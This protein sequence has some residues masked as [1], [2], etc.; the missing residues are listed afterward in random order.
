[1]PRTYALGAVWVLILAIG[2]CSES[3]TSGPLDGGQRDASPWAND[4][5][6]APPNDDDR[7][8]FANDLD[9]CP[10]VFNADQLDFDKDGVGDPCDPDPPPETCGDAVVASARM[11]PNVLVVLD[12]S[13]SMDRDGKW[14][15]ATAALDS[16]SENLADQL[17]LGLALFS[18]GKDRCGAPALVLAVDAHSTAEFQSSY[19]NEGPTGY[20]P[21][22]RALEY[23]RTQGWLKNT[24][25]PEDAKRSKNLLLVTDGQPNC[26][27]GHES[28]YNYSD[29][30]ATLEQATLLHDTGVAI[31]V[32]GFGDGV[33]GNALND[34]AEKGGTDNPNDANN[35]Y[36][37]ADN[38]QELESALV[39]IGV[40]VGSCTLELEGKP[41]DPTRIYVLLDSLPLTR[42]NADGFVY[43]GAT[44]TIELRG[45]ACDAVKTPP[46]VAVKV[47]FGCPPDGGPPVIK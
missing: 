32:V 38:A 14:E 20:T 47:I 44:N 42:D 34:L 11:E 6:A 2:G 45:T 46:G 30:E 33:D 35:R 4:T 37:Q 15:D 31:H 24:S 7:D 8:G 18:G 25:D 41:A 28:D 9:N 27:V 21:M 12:R 16:L 19:A 17:R 26:A 22:R 10:E 5:W 1:V 29:L 40:Q 36:Y 23:P 3:S 39:A 13:L 43:D